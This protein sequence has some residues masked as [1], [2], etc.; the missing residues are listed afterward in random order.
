[1]RPRTFR[2]ELVDGLAPGELET[3]AKASRI[4]EEVAAL[5]PSARSAYAG[6]TAERRW[7]DLSD[8]STGSGGTSG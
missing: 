8:D 5:P 3:L 1:M 6:V 2:A 7:S 4:L